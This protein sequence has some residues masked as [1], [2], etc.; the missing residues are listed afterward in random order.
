[1]DLSETAQSTWYRNKADRLLD[2]LPNVHDRFIFLCIARGCVGDQ[3]NNQGVHRTS[4]VTKAKAG[5]KGTDDWV[6]NSIER[7]AD[8][9]P[10]LVQEITSGDYEGYFCLSN[11]IYEE[12]TGKLDEFEEALKK[13]RM[14]GIGPWDAKDTRILAP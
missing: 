13:D 8:T 12:L 2:E 3:N 10:P 6:T 14:L 5:W 7:L 9:N 4:I 11:E 1:M